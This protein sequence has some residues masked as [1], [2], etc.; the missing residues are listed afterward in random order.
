MNEYDVVKKLV[1]PI[2]PVGETNAD[3]ERF[4]NLEAMTEL[5]GMLL[6]DIADVARHNK[7]RIEHTMN[8]A[9]KHAHAFLAA[10]GIDDY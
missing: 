4:G 5:V 10:N 8:K 1:G 7:D 2:G 6:T 9:G 3:T